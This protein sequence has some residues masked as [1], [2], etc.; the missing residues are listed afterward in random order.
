MPINILFIVGLPGSG[1]SMLAKKINKDND[2][3]YHIIDDPK[4]FNKDIKSYLDKDL[5]I[6]D[7]SLCFPQNRE[8][9]VKYFKDLVPDAKMD[10][11]FFENDPESCLLNSQMRNRALT[12]TLKPK[13]NVESFIKNLNKFYTIPDGSNVVSVYRRPMED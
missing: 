5:I 12:T 13:K 1:K 7:P 2:N 8:S 9:A 3:K 10:W 4:D 6:T 11:I